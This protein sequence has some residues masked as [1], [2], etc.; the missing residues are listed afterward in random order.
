[1]TGE[2][3]LDKILVDSNDDIYKQI[4]STERKLGHEGDE[5]KTQEKLFENYDLVEDKYPKNKEGIM[6]VTR[7][8]DGT[9]NNTIYVRYYYI[10]KVELKV[11]YLEIETEKVVADEKIIYGHEGDKYRTEEKEI[12]T[13]KLVRVDGNKEGYLPGENSEVIY[14]YARVMVPEET[15]SQTVQTIVISNGNSVTNT[16]T[17]IVKTT[18]TEKINAGDN[19][20]NIV[21]SIIFIVVFVNIIQILV[22]RNK[23]YFLK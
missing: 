10:K 11:K 5:Y 9:L 21:I 22:A 23:K 15:H 4:D 3:I 2:K 7:N 17:A 1:M 12:N 19:T 13:Y 16:P 8:A 20:P 14:Y 18:Q 6:E